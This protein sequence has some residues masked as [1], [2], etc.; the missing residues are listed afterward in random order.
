MKKIQYGRNITGGGILYARNSV[1]TL[2]KRGAITKT[3]KL[4]SMAD[5]RVVHPKESKNCPASFV[6]YVQL[7][8]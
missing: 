8:K 1:K 3:N 5:Y 7:R 4:D 6:K 2:T